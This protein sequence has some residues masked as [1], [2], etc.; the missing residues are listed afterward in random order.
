MTVAV[1]GVVVVD[2]KPPL[3]CGDQG[4]TSGR[5]PR[6]KDPKWSPG[7]GCSCSAYA[8]GN[9]CS[10]SCPKLYWF[11]LS[12]GSCQRYREGD[13]VVWA[14]QRLYIHSPRPLAYVES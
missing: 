10:G 9:S 13:T 3:P 8:S 5:T 2:S 12:L 7:S 14:P 4:K 11:I 6:V 1:V